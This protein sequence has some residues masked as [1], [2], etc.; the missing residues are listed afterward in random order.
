[1]NAREGEQL[2]RDGYLVLEGFMGTE[3][4]DSLRRRI[5]EVFLEKGA[6]AGSEF[7]QEPH[8]RRLAN[9]VNCGEVFERAVAEPR[10]L[11]YV[12]HVLGPHFKLSSLNVRD[13]NP[14]S[15]WIQPLHCD[16]GAVPDELGFWVC[17]AIWLLD[18]FTAENGATRFVPGSHRW[19]K[20]P[21]FVLA[22]PEA[23]HPDERL[24]TGKAGSV[25]IMNT[26]L[27]HG[28]TAN[29]T[30]GPRRAMHAFYCRWD[31]PQQQYQKQLLSVDVQRRLTSDL[32]RLLALDDPLNDELSSKH[33]GRSGFLK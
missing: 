30:S 19:G 18:D 25:V 21:E 22:D 9:L 15:T 29:R 16:V 10:I 26:H 2:D 32:R 31:K 24:L 12:A 33:S 28:A 23:P 20:L 5:E 7:R 6:G 8:T 1:M 11:Q 13:P 4:L 3:L 14:D 17:N 27:W